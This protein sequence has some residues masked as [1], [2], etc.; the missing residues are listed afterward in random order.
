MSERDTVN[1][2]K[3]AKPFIFLERGSTLAHA[4]RTVAS[5]DPTSQT[6]TIDSAAGFCRREDA[7]EDNDG[8]TLTSKQSCGKPLFVEG[9]QQKSRPGMRIEDRRLE[10][11]GDT[12][13]SALVK[14]TAFP[15]LLMIFR[16]VTVHKA[17][18]I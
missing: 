9:G 1:K 11:V 6:T 7:V 14:M 8:G 18:K 16:N 4:L 10:G 12:V 3:A 2:G 17:E 15:L 13:I 5:S